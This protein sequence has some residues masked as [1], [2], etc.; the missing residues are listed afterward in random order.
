M[1]MCAG[2]FLS[3]EQH[4]HR[5]KPLIFEADLW[6]KREKKTTIETIKADLATIETIKAV[7]ATIDT[8]IKAG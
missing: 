1:G 3:N 7:L 2:H 8:I 5:S 4:V 6:T